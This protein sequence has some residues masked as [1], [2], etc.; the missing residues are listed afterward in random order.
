ME[1]EELQFLAPSSS[2]V[3]RPQA[4]SLQASQAARALLHQPSLDSGRR[5]DSRDSNAAASSWDAHAPP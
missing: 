3:R 2:L 1:N 4:H 5:Q